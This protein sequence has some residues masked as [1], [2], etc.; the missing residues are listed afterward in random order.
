MKTAVSLWMVL[1]LAALPG[2]VRADKDPAPFHPGERLTYTLYWE[3][4]PAGTA[5]LEVLPIETCQDVPAYHFAMQVES[6]GFIDTFYK[7]RDRIDAFTDKE[8]RHSLLYTKKQQEG[9]H[10]RDVRV[11]FN[12]D[13]SQARYTNFGKREKPVHIPEGTFDP[14][15]IFYAFRFR[16]L[17]EGTALEASVSDGKKCVVGKARI[18]SRESISVPAGTFDTYLVEPDL[19]DVGGVFKKSKDATLQVWVSSDARHM[20]VKIKSRV[21]VGSFSAE[22]DSISRR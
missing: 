22:L 2:P 20:P 13:R 18:L 11:T 16:T 3:M 1:L 12:W 21:V 15:S 5:S 10:S 17:Q 14:L 8:M 19:R 7:V 6:N 9:R 4:I